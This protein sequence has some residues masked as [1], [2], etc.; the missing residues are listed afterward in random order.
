ML[1]DF[2]LIT[3]ASCSF[4]VALLHVYV[5][6]KGAPAYRFFGAGEKLAS[7]AERGSLLPTMLT[8]GITVVFLIFAAYYV[9]AVGWISPLPMMHTDWC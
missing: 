6:A 1:K 4:L 5:I 3:S 2:L 8:A 7:M 9:A